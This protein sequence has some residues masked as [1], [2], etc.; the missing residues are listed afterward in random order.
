MDEITI[1]AVGKRFDHDMPDE[2]A[3]YT[4]TLWMSA[5]PTLTEIEYADGVITCYWSQ[6]PTEEDLADIQ[7]LREGRYNVGAMSGE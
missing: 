4:R 5:K 2:L 3:D 1:L 6:D 7:A